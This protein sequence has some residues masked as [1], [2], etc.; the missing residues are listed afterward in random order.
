MMIEMTMLSTCYI[1]FLI[2]DDYVL[3]DGVLFSSLGL[4][5]NA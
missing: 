1:L 3:Y 5:I 4:Q 2:D